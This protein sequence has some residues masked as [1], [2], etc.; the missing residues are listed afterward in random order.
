MFRFLRDSRLAALI[1]VVLGAFPFLL[2]NPLSLDDGLRHFEMAKLM[3]QKGIMGT[4]GWSE[5]LYGGYLSNLKTDPW[6]LSDLLMVPLTALSAETALKI[7]TAFTLACVAGASVLALRSLRI[8]K[9]FAG[10]ALAVL[11]FGDQQFL[12]RLLIARPFGLMTAVFIFSLYTVIRRRYILA[13]IS[14]SVAV[15][16]SQLFVFP[17][18]VFVIAALWLF[19]TR[20]KRDA[21]LLAG[22]VLCGLLL[23]L[24]LHPY[25]H[26]YVQYL[27]S[28]FI[29]IPFLGN[30]V[31]L[32]KEMTSGFAD[33]SGMGVIILIGSAVILT[34]MEWR[35]RSRAFLR[36]PSF[37][38]ILVT[39]S[40]L[41]LYVFW[42]RTIDLLWPVLVLLNTGLISVQLKPV[43]KFVHLLRGKK[44]LRILGSAYASAQIL[45]VPGWFAL[46]NHENT[47][48][49]YEVLQQLPSGARVLN[50]DWE[51]F[52]AYV[53]VRPD[54]EYAAGIDPSFTFLTEPEAAKALQQLQDGTLETLPG[55]QEA[56]GSMMKLLL[57][58]YPADYIAV[59]RG[60][61]DELM[62]IAGKLPFLKPIAESPAMMIYSVQ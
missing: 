3:A 32:S 26:E 10:I 48:N 28:A 16:L 20:R 15:L 7:F 46:H 2:P 54:L 51:R 49:V 55:S 17:L 47:L 23:G 9:T 33:V 42:V 22:C 24:T 4:E 6:F 60:K 43:M 52:F 38:L 29:Q 8:S 62:K 39:F 53:S 34:F 56:A 21:V 27:Y 44:L 57:K 40:L 30:T 1:V 59:H 58:Y 61:Y 12:G 5:F 25:P 31:E 18:V 11:M 37:F 50:L 35:T 36:T 19:C 45:L 14:M 41:P 13:G